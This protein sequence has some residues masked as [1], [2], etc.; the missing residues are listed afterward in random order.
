MVNVAK[1]N[2]KNLATAVVAGPVIVAVDADK[3]GDYDGGIFSSCGTQINH[4]VTVVGFV[5]DSHWV[6]QNSWGP[7]WGEDGFMRIKFGNTCAICE[8]GQY[9][10]V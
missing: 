4:A 7:D 5:K 3:F 2:C 9:A 10:T 1:G 6:I 8:Y